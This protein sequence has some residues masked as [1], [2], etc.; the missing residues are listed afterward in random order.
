MGALTKVWSQHLSSLRWRRT[1]NTHLLCTTKHVVVEIKQIPKF[2]FGVRRYTH[3]QY[4]HF[5]FY[6]KSQM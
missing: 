4:V 5:F 6:I 3:A 2:V 1:K